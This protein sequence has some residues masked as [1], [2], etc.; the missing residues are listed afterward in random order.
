[1]PVVRLD[2]N[3]I[4]NSLLCPAGKDQVEFC[5][6][7]QKGL[8]ILVSAK[9]PGRGTYYL[10]YKDSNGKT[11]HQ[12]IGRT[13]DITLADA[14]RQAKTIKAEIAL[15]ADPR[16]DVKARKEALTFGQL[17]EQYE[18]YAKPRKHSFDRDEQLYRIRIQPKFA[19]V[20]LQSINRR[21]IQQFHTELHAEGLAPASCDHHLKL[22][23]HMFN[24]AIDWDL[25]DGQNPVA[26][27]PLF[28]PENVVNNIPSD[29]ELE[30]LL[31]VLQTDRNRM[32]CLLAQF[33]LATGMRVGEATSSR[34]ADVN[35]QNRVLRL[36]ASNTKGGRHRS[37]VLSDVAISVLEQLGTKDKHEYLFINKHTGKPL[38]NV[39]KQWDRIRRV[40]GL[41][42]LRC[43]DLRHL[44]ATLMLNAGVG[45]MVVK[46]VLGHRSIAITA[47]HYAHVSSRSMHSA[48]ATSSEIILRFMQSA[49]QNDSKEET[50]KAA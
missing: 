49:M 14:R 47:K 42:K 16:G 11:C 19:G 27:V 44:A 43:H 46:E 39:V 50:L 5:C 24:L 48:A 26:R 36:N 33:L 12:K 35:L 7:E 3:F 23:K 41:P 21:Q 37:V 32:V 45:L 20:S 9:S 29:L 18:A 1:M 38:K 10:R 2:Q 8:Y 13:S 30:R 28:N 6:S 4:I 15:G 34:W 17:W 25:F 22:M 31:H 40:A